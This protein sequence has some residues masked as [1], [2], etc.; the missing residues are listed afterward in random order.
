MDVLQEPGKTRATGLP[1]I[2]FLL[3]FIITRT[4]QFNNEWRIKHITH[5]GAEWGF[6]P[7]KT[8]KGELTENNRDRKR[9]YCNR[10]SHNKCHYNKK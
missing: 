8:C 3:A 2:L 5:Q 7:N 10:H 1:K 6:T 9:P 4:L